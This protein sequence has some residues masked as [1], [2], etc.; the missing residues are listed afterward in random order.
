MV[1]SA[2]GEGAM[3]TAYSPMAA[4]RCEPSEPPAGLT[5]VSGRRTP[6]PRLA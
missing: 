1:E 6:K 4:G 2:P 3:F 5:G